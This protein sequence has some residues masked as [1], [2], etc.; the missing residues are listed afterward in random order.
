[1][2]IDANNQ[3]YENDDASIAQKKNNVHL[4]PLQGAV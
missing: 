1:M 3:E 2:T 4:M